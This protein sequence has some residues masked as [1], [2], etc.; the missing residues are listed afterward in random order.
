MSDPES[1]RAYLLE[2]Q[3]NRIIGAPRHLG[4]DALPPGEVLVKVRWSCVNHK[5]A[6]VTVPGNRVTRTYPLVPGV[7]LAGEVISSSDPDITT[8][9]LILANGYD[10]GITR[11]GGFAEYARLPTG[12][13]IGLPKGLSAREAMIMGTA[14]FTAAA[15]VEEL[16]RRGLSPGD[17]PVLVTGA[18]G[19]VGS[20]AVAI[21]ATRGYEVVAST[22]KTG[23]HGW[24]RSLG[25]TKT[26]GRD[27]LEESRGRALGP[28]RWAGA[29]DSVGGRT[30]AMVLRSLRRGATVAASGLTGGAD[31]STTVYP[32]IV[33]SVTLAGVDAVWMDHEHRSAIWHRLATDMHPQDLDKIV[34][35]EVSL[36]EVGPALQTVLDGK[37]RGRILVEPEA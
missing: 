37:I 11:H 24:L 22:G 1:F 10:I 6:M 33:R 27:D 18:S 20:L 9:S 4:F 2:H 29:I 21:L 35:R 13:A 28:E 19:G 17:G 14:G 8:G 26:I 31:L 30:L 36:D 23:E 34:N 5:D 16:E 7:D 12:W 32:F 3:G 25:A 15:S